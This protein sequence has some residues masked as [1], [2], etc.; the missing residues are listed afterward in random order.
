M[1]ND[2]PDHFMS[3]LSEVI[4]LQIGLYFPQERWKDLIRRIEYAFPDLGF[5]DAVSCIHSLL[6]APLTKKQLDILAKHLTVGE[7]YFFR[8]KALLQILKDRILSG[9]VRT[10]PEDR[11]SINFWSAGCCSGEEPYSIAILIDQM[12]SSFVDWKI[13]ILA[14]DI[15][16]YFL[17]KARSGIYTQ[18]SFRETPDMIMRRYFTKIGNNQFEISSHI[19]NMVHFTQLNL[20]ETDY[21]SLLHN[22]Q[23]VDVIFC[24]NVI[25]YFAPELRTQVIQRFADSLLEGG[26]LIVSPSETAFIQETSLV[27]VRFPGGLFFRKGVPRKEDLEKDEQKTEK[28]VSFFYGDFGGQLLN[29]PTTSRSLPQFSVPHSEI[30][31]TEKEEIDT[32]QEKKSAEG[33][34]THVPSRRK[35]DGIC[36]RGDKEAFHES[37]YEVYQEA[38]SLYEGGQYENSA[39]KLLELITHTQGN[40]EAFL[41][42][43]E[44]MALLAK[45]YANQGKLTEAK[46][47]CEQAIDAE[48]LHPSYYYLLGTIYQEQGIL[49]EA[50]K[51]FKQALYLD[52]KFIVVHFSLGNLTQKKGKLEESR[53]HLKNALSLLLSMDSEDIVP[54]SEGTT[55]GTMLKMVQSMIE[56][57]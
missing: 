25:M 52:Q 29:I 7:T 15:N 49:E 30:V 20:V 56:K 21:S 46:R 54:H 45:A 41:L 6:A 38:L 19:K 1:S 36:G 11:K 33:D 14:T 44:S 17:Q 43:G 53:K 27:P 23:S 50:M 39:E 12:M 32:Q 4:R 13:S 26:W 3:Q 16:P 37:M 24:R 35:T 55:V 31:R 10:R 22:I 42:N 48:K 51:L 9:W 47:W 8:D 34:T 5:E 40:D 2:I 28:K 57:G 18:W